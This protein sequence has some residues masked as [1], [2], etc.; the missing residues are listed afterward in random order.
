MASATS[1]SFPIHFDDIHADAV[2]E[3]F[4]VKSPLSREGHEP[5]YF[6]GMQ[7]I[8]LKSGRE[9]FAC[10]NCQLVYNALG[11]VRVHVNQA[12][13]K[14]S[15]GET[16]ADRFADGLRALLASRDRWKAEA[17]K[18]S[19]TWK[20]RALQAEAKLKGLTREFNALKRKVESLLS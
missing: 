12:H 9:L 11:A 5:I 6:R 14:G 20:E 7:G 1:E 16:E 10:N 18:G 15:S 13:G 3:L 4:N 17:D 19:T 8:R 2:A